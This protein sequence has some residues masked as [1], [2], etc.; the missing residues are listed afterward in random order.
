M[1]RFG[2]FLVCF[3]W[4][5]LVWGQRIGAIELVDAFTGQSVSISDQGPDVT[6]VFI[7][8]SLNC[9]YAKLYEERILDLH[10]QY[11]GSNV[12]FALVNPHSWME[13]ENQDHMQQ[14]TWAQDAGIPFLMDNEQEFTRQTGARKIPE[15]IVISSGP[16]GYSIAYQGAIDNNAQSPAS[17]SVRYLDNAIQDI[18]SRKRPGPAVTRAVG[19]NIR[20]IH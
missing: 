8:T 15:A 5:S 2:C 18:L 6:M 20:T 1:R 10:Q 7:V 17:V 4:L 3:F 12:F 13:E 14:L 19:C 11:S 9:P 16:T